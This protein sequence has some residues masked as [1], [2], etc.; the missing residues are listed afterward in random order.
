MAYYKT[1]DALP[2]WAKP[3]IKKL[4]DAGALRGDENGNINLSEDMMRG[5]IIG[6]RYT[7]HVAQ[8]LD[9]VESAAREAAKAEVKRIF[10]AAFAVSEK[11]D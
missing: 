9:G 11:C 1:Y 5:L 6:A 2:D 7:Y 3:E 8:S 10:D 4:M